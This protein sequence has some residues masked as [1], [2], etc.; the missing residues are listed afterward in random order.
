MVVHPV[1]IP[2]R[3]VRIMIRRPFPTTPLQHRIPS[4]HP[5][6][7]LRQIRP[8]HPQLHQHRIVRRQPRRRKQGLSQHLRITKLTVQLHRT[9]PLPLIITPEADVEIVRRPQRRRI[10]AVPH[11]RILH[12]LHPGPVLRHKRTIERRRAVLLPARRLQFRQLSPIRR[13]HHQPQQRLIRRHRGIPRPVKRIIHPHQ[14]IAHVLIYLRHHP[15]PRRPR[16]PRHGVIRKLASRF[17]IHIILNHRPVHLP[18]NHRHPRPR[19]RSLRPILNE[20]RSLEIR[21]PGDPP[22]QHA[23]RDP[24]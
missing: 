4:V 7:R 16:L 9:P 14:I 11:P 10:P 19:H 21:R 6:A 17:Q 23:I 20:R 3:I 5:P 18:R 13:Q 15:D 22:P 24:A 12:N 8:V 1:E 2:V